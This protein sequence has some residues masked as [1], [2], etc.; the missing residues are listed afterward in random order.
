LKDLKQE[1]QENMLELDIVQ[2]QPCLEEEIKNI[3]E[4]KK[5]NT[6]LPEG[7]IEEKGMDGTFYYRLVKTDLTDEELKNLIAF[8][9]LS[10]LKSI[11]NSLCFSVIVTIIGFLI[12][13]SNL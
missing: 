11:R 3:E 4:M 10:Y 13:I 9:Q 12:V 6:K 5:N 1:L 2:K 7:I 8:R